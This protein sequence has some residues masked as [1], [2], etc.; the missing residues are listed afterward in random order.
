MTPLRLLKTLREPPVKLHR[1]LVLLLVRPLRLQAKPPLL[2]VKPAPLPL[3]TQ[4]PLPATP[5]LPQVMLPMLLAKLRSKQRRRHETRT[6]A[7]T[8]LVH[9]GLPAVIHAVP[10]VG[11]ILWMDE[12]S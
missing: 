4:L 12:T 2:L 11:P 8:T 3:R 6:I 7:S 9:A 5:L 1:K 10:I